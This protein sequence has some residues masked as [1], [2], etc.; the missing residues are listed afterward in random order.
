MA[1]DT[2]KLKDQARFCLQLMERLEKDIQ[3]DSDKESWWGVAN[4]TQKKADIIR[5]RRE[6]NTLNKILYPWEDNE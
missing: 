3:C 4:Y 1:I 6:L 2:K 5:L